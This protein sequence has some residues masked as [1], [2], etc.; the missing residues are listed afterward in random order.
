M[1]KN[2]SNF[3]G[4]TYTFFLSNYDLPN[5]NFYLYQIV[6]TGMMKDLSTPLISLK[7]IGEKCKTGQQGFEQDRDILTYCLG[8]KSC[9]D[10]KSIEWIKNVMR[11]ENLFVGLDG[12]NFPQ[13]EALEDRSVQKNIICGLRDTIRWKY[14]RFFQGR[15]LDILWTPNE[16]V[17]FN[18]MGD[19]KMIWL[20]PTGVY[21]CT[22]F[23]MEE[24]LNVDLETINTK[25]LRW[26]KGKVSEINQ[27]IRKIEW[28][29]FESRFRFKKL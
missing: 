2:N 17:L 3:L 19:D 26:E 15:K 21:K 6:S 11:N 14:Y 5:D 12:T 10:K 20:E 29:S 7:K 27:A 16:T 4:R 24:P 22:D 1:K 9:I 8:G 28:N 23:R 18:I 25:D 13:I